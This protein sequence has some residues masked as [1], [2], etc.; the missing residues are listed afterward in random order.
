MQPRISYAGH[1]AHTELALLDIMRGDP[2]RAHERLEAQLERAL[3]LGL[4]M[5]L[6]I[7]V[8]AL[9]RSEL[10]LGRLAQARDRLEGLRRCSCFPA[11]SCCS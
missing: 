10:A 11:G 8:I 9:A 3:Q 7:V 2:E 1:R 4:V 5:V 6:P